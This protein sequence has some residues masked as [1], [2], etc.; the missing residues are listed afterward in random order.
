MLY[1]ELTVRRYL[2]LR[3]RHEGARRAFGA[4]RG[5]LRDRALR[6]RRHGPT[7]SPAR[8]RRATRQRVG[9]AQ[10]LLGE[11]AVLVLDEPTVGLD[12]VQTVDDAAMR[13]R[14]L[15][16][17]TVL[18][19]TRIL[20]EAR[21][22]LHAASSSWRAGGWWRRTARRASPGAW[23]RCGACS[24][25]SVGGPPAEGAAGARG[26]AGRSGGWTQD[27]ADGSTG[28]ALVLRVEQADPV[29]RACRRVD[30]RA[31]AGRSSRC[32]GDWLTA[33]ETCSCAP[34]D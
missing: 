5:G 30:R 31:T 14:T 29:Q 25:C 16:G 1:P 11:P 15:E 32:D 27:A 20:S 23:Q 24:P 13:C 21:R 8:C 3:R 2:P 33:R 17:C 4:A 28:P 34:C 18:L 19:S 22:A 6:P 26:A 12:P 9:L 10:A 7:V